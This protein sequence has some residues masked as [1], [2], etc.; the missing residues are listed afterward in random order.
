MNPDQENVMFRSIIALFVLAA[1]AGARLTHA[2]VIDSFE[3][4]PFSMTLTSPGSD[5]DVQTPSPIHCIANVRE[6]EILFLPTSTG[7]L[8]ANLTLFQNVDDALEAT[9]PFGDDGSVL[10]KYETGGPWDLTDGG[11]NDQFSLRITGVGFGLETM[12]TVRDEDGDV[13]TVSE[14]VNLAGTHHIEFS[15]FASDVDFDRIEEIYVSLLA[16]AGSTWGLQHFE[17]TRK[18]EYAL[19]WDI[20]DPTI[21]VVPG[22][23]PIGPTWG[24]LV[25][26]DGQIPILG[27]HL[28]LEGFAPIYNGLLIQGY[29]SG[30]EI[31][32]YGETSILNVFWEA[33]AW[34]GASF[35]MDFLSHEDVTYGA[36][37]IGEPD[38]QSSPEGIV[39]GH[40]LLLTNMEGLPDGLF[41]QDV[42]VFPSENQDIQFENVQVFPVGLRGTQAG[43]KLLFDASGSNVD[44]GEPLYEVHL[45]GTYIPGSTIT[46]TAPRADEVSEVELTTRPTV[47]RT[48][49]RLV[50]SRPAERSGS[51]DVFDVAGRLV[52]QLPIQIG[53]RTISWDGR[54]RDGNLVA[55]GVYLA[56]F[57]TAEGSATS[58]IVRLR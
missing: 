14:I 17:T 22:L 57:A 32:S 25:P 5:V 49:S 53:A 18:L 27:S 43:Y 9:F 40:D 13:G 41:H 15:Q 21:Q 47:S 7:T 54:G 4:G 8:S 11:I 34:Q 45:S 3:S 51:V 56:R 50:L 24:W 12:L 23:P 29:D 6:V 28:V 33:S 37:L 19:A 39:I 44:L 42:L 36:E 55:S 35:Q 48:I 16:L 1:F 58:R 20:L 26:Y 10:C 52:R 2:T 46:G 31:G 30:G 38:V